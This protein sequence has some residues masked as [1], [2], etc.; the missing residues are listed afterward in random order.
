MGWRVCAPLS[1]RHLDFSRLLFAA[2]A[3]QANGIQVLWT[4]M[5][6]GTPPD[7]RVTDADFASRFAEFTGA[8][9]RQLRRH[10][11]T[12]SIYNPINEIG[13]LAWALASQRILGSDCSER[14][15]YV[16]KARLV[17]AALRGIA[18]IRAEDSRARFIHI[19]PL[20]HV[21]APAWQPELAPAAAEFCTYQWLVW[22]MLIGRKAPKMGATPA[23]IDWIGINHYHDAQWEFG[24]GAWLD[25]D[26][27]DVRRRPFASLLDEAWQRYALP[28]VVA[29]TSHVG[30]GR[31]RWLDEIAAHTEAAMSAGAKVEGMCLYPAVDRPDW[32]NQNHWHN[33][34]LWDAVAPGQRRS[35][36]GFA[37][38][39]QTGHR[40][41]S[42]VA[43]LAGPAG[44]PRPQTGLGSDLRWVRLAFRVTMLACGSDEGRRSILDRID[45]RQQDARI[46]L[47]RGQREC[48]AGLVEQGLRG[49]QREDGLAVTILVGH[50]LLRLPVSGQQRYPV[51]AVGQDERVEQ[52]RR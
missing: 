48:G 23:A 28:I 46:G 33:S 3:A 43:A 21:V 15:G 8:A 41:R 13:F 6:Y 36:T 17:Q 51:I 9:A 1:Y 5:H 10:C 50:E 14:D 26:T 45:T 25:W 19:E 35:G 52:Y 7:I 16:V 37:V 24:T 49:A 29:E 20:I 11:G 31:A 2:E 18:A 22:D 27:R 40:L 42:N 47:A 30:Q 4:L 12:A 34:G 44:R 38:R 39:A 32:N